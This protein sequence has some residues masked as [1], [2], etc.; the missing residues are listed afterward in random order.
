[1]CPPYITI[2]PEISAN[3]Q[4]FPFSHARDF[5]KGRGRGNATNP[6]GGIDILWN[7]EGQTAVGALFLQNCQLKFQTV[8]Y[9]V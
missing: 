1:M 5:R 4:G 9:N 8:C 2:L 3:G 6:L 7:R